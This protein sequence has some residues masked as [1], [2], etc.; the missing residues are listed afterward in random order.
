[1]QE[2][3]CG[4][5]AKGWF[6]I[7]ELEAV[8]GHPGAYFGDEEFAIVERHDRRLE[9][10]GEGSGEEL[11]GSGEYLG[12]VTL[13]V[14]LEEDAAGV[15]EGR[16]QIIETAHGDFFFIEIVG[17]GGCGE[18]RVEHREDGAG[19][20]VGGDV[21]LG[22]A[23]GSAE[24]DSVGDGPEGIGCGLGQERGVRGSGGFEGDDFATVAAG[25][26]LLSEL[27][28]VSADVEDKV[29]L[30]ESEET[31]EAKFRR[32]VDVGLPDLEADGL[33]EGAQFFS[34]G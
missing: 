13:N 26:A 24:G 25:S 11:G 20:G 18:M 17:G 10:Y 34:N 8:V 21:D 1:L 32:T 29:D 31:A 16:E 9:L 15:V 27:A 33:A 28:V 14:E 5:V 4:D 3:A 6:E 23:S 2:S 30:E 19:E 7:P 22:F 12:L